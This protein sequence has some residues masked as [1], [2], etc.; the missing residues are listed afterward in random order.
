MDLGI[1]NK[2]ALVT[3]GASGI[4]K[5]IA[6]DLALEGV[7]VII[8]SRSD[9]KLK[10]ALT[11]LKKINNKCVGFK[12]ELT[13]DNSPTELVDLVMNQ[14]GSI[15]IVVNNVG[16][17]LGILDPLCPLDDWYNLFKL[18]MGV[19]IEINN[20]VIPIMK[21]N[22]W[23]RIVNITAGAS[24]ENSG[25]VPYSSLKAAYTAYSRSMA[26]VLALEKT[27]IVMSAVLPGVVITEDG[28]WTQS[29]ANSD[30][31]E[32]YLKDRT[33]LGRFG[34]PDE[35]SPIV[36]LLCSEKASFCIGSVIPVEGGQARHYF[37][38][39]DDN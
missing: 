24:M 25:P 19:A 28:H 6:V 16:A 37:Q 39:V 20:K 9:E 4:G 1:K 11:E 15:D 5:A 27:G 23:G 34:Q 3:G 36:V 17:T 35:I 22:N 30:H 38:K 8:T 12:C 26:R 13:E 29:N 14:F 2:I 18:I 31:A 32:K 10:D 7:T 33:V 21:K